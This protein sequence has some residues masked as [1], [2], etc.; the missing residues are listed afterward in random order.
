LRIT[1]TTAAVIAASAPERCRLPRNC[2]TNGAPAKI[3]SIEGVNVTQVVIAA[4][5]TPAVTAENGAASRNAARNPTNCVTR[6]RGPGVVSASP[7]PSTISG[8]VI[9]P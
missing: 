1:P 4:P 8:A 6:M 5:S 3:H 9:Q 7:S 2:S